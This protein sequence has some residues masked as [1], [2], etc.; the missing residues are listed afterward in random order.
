MV[1][2]K[3]ARPVLR[4]PR[5]SNV[6]GLPD[7]DDTAPAIMAAGAD[8]VF[9]VKANRPSLLGA[10]KTLPWRKVPFRVWSASTDRGHGR[11]A[12]R[13]LKVIDVPDL[14]RWPEF[15]G[16]AQVAQLRRTVTRGGKKSVE[17][18]YL[19]TSAAHHDA[20]PAVLA[21]VNG[22]WC[23][24]NQLHHVRDVTFDE[25][26][27]QVRTGR[28]PH[29]MATPRNTT[30]GILRL[31]GWDNIAAALRHHARDPQRAITYALTC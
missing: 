6:P 25:D 4:G 19:I 17:V 23:I 31:A 11:T 28:S 30:I 13:T 15:T 3:P 16:V 10:L 2:G 8:Y 27:S 22:H 1:R 5:H 12:T 14:P 7:H 18:V 20:P 29:V 9:T 26:R 21:W 24:E